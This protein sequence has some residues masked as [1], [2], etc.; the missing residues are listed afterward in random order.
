MSPSF[1]APDIKEAEERPRQEVKLSW[2]RESRQ[3]TTAEESPVHVASGRADN[4]MGTENLQHLK[5]SEK[6]HPV[7]KSES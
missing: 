3:R 5:L 4:S 1:P 2:K 7:R 6:Q